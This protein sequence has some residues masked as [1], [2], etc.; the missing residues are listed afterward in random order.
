VKGGGNGSSAG[1]EGLKA[2]QGT[3]E[4]FGQGMVQVVPPIR[5]R[6]CAAANGKEKR[7]RKVN[8]NRVH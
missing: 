1:C 3:E 4:K 6:D 8:R 2:C 5:R 7:K